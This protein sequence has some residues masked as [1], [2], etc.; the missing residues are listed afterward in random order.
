MLINGI[1]MVAYVF[2]KVLPLLFNMNILVSFHSLSLAY[3]KLLCLH[4]GRF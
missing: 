4:V 1:V 3:T 2:N